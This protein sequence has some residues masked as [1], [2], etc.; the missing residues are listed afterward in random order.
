[1]RLKIIIAVVV[2]AIAGVLGYASTKPDNFRYES[3]ITINAAPDKIYAILN[4]LRTG[5]EWSSWNKV[6]PNMKKTYGG[7]AS[8]KGQTFEW[9][10]NKDIGAGKIEIVDTTPSK[11]TMN[12]DFI[13]PME[14]HSKVDYLI[15]PVDGGTKVTSAMYGPQP[16]FG[17]VISVFMDCEK[18]I[19]E[20]TQESLSALKAYA[21]KK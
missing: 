17:K 2:L 15:E 1:M 3:S 6:D 4:D 8:G 13:K 11:I 20:K 10:G 9:D 12:L 14:G 5:D 7:P 19:D 16:F 21:E 18:M